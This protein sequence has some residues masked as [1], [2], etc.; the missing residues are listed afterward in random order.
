M[1][2]LSRRDIHGLITTGDLVPVLATAM[3]RVSERAIEQPMRTQLR[4]APR[5]AMGIMP[6]YL[7]DPPAYGIKLLSLFPDNPAQGRSS[8]AGAMMLFDVKTGL[9]RACLDASALTALRTAAAS[10]LA[11]KVLAREDATVLAV[12]GCGEQAHAHVEAMRAVRPIGSVRVWGRD[13]AKAAAFAAQHAGA[14]AIADIADAIRP[15]DIVC[16]VTSAQVP[17]VL[18]GMLPPGVHLAAAGAS[19]PPAIEIDPGIFAEVSLFTDYLPSL[20][21][22]AFEY[23]QARERGLPGIDDPTE[24]GLVLAGTKPGRTSADERTMY[25]SLGIAAQDLAAA[26]FV[27]GRAEAQGVGTVVDFS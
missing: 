16:T 9:P 1:R 22:E 12:I 19:R 15:A 21:G 14:E 20:Q 13:P 4:F 6:G 2:I 18:P 27:V 26:S 23:A 11:T 25:R 8:H 5:K 10:A 24:I 17:L 7:S 3:Q